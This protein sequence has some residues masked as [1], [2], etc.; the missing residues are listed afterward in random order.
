MSG[1]AAGIAVALG[2]TRALRYVLFEVRPTDPAT[3]A[4]VT[5]LLTFAAL[6]ACYVP[7]QRATRTDLAVARRHK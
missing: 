2:V 5:I 4:G 3:F 6:G 1:V 7:A